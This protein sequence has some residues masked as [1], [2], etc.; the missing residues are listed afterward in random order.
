MTTAAR[1]L[2]NFDGQPISLYEFVRS[3]TPTITGT[4]YTT[5][6][7]Y[8]NADQDIMYGGNTY[9]AIA[10]SD[11]GIRQ[12]GDEVSDQLSIRLPA[13]L[14]VPQLFAI[15]PPDDPIGLSIRRMHYGETDAFL[16]WVGTVGLAKRESDLASVLVCHTASAR[17]NRGGLRMTWQRNCPHA[18]YDS[19][20]KVDPGGF[21]VV[22]TIG[23]IAGL[24]IAATGFDLVGNGFF[25]GGWV[26]KVMPDGHVLRR[27]I[28]GHF[29]TAVALLG[30]AHGF[31]VGDVIQGFAGC[32]RS[33]AMC[34]IQFSNLANF[35]GHPY[36]AGKSPF[37][38]DPVF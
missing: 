7:R 20:C 2:S 10:I 9:A 3:T 22:G 27:G 18:L 19:Q 36:L 8:T 15:A 1:D 14:Y 35:G 37:D 28:T 29:E 32:D 25:T 4:P 12:S 38:G 26:E 11:D 24:T 5:Y 13:D 6:Y 34:D 17:L 33:S 30:S 23:A 16:S 21:V 31:E